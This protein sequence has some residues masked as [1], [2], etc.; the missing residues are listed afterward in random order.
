[1][2]AGMHINAITDLPFFT[3]P[4]MS[5]AGGSGPND[6][7]RYRSYINVD[8]GRGG[9]RSGHHEDGYHGENAEML[10]IH[11]GDR[12]FKESLEH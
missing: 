1:M 3:D 9:K 5:R 8:L 12:F 2:T 7:R 4:Y 10:F 6:H 11:P